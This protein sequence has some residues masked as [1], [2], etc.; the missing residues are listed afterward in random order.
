[1]K[2]LKSLISALALLW[3]L[4][5]SAQTNVATN[6][7]TFVRGNLDIKY[8]SRQ[9]APGTKGIKDVYTVN[10][11]VCNSAKFSGTIT[12]TPQ[13]IEGVFSKSV[14]QPRSLYYD[15]ALDVINP[16]NVAQTRNVGRM[17]G[18][19]PIASDGSYQYDKG[20]LEASIF[21]M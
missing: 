15:V 13:I 14:T 8:N 7:P 21:P 20:N 19:G 11:N 10:I 4:A 1:M 17:L 9:S 16:K 5:V 18:S 2:Q 3:A 6:A 12:D